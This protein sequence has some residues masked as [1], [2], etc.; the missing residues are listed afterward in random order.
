MVVAAVAWVFAAILIVVIWPIIE[1][2]KDLVTLFGRIV[3][4]EKEVGY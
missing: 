4:N 2:W 3:R 1:S